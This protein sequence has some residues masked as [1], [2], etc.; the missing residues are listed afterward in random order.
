MDIQRKRSTYQSP[1]VDEVG[2]VL[3][4]TI[5]AESSTENQIDSAEIDQWDYIL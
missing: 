4:F 3:D 5:L 1:E 2:L